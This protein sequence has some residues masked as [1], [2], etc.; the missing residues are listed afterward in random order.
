MKFKDNQ[1]RPIYHQDRI[2]I[3]IKSNVNLIN[4]D[5]KKEQ[6]QKQFGV[7]SIDNI[8]EK[9]PVQKIE[10]AFRQR[11]ELP[12]KVKERIHSSSVTVPDLSQIHLIQFSEKIDA[13]K[14]IKE[15]NKNPEIEYAE[16]V[17]CDY[18]QDVPNDSLYSE[19]QHLPQIKAEQAWE[20]IKGENSDSTILIGICDTGTDWNH[21][22]LIDNLWQNL[23]EDA[24]KDG[25]VIEW[26]DSLK[27]F[28]LD[29]GD[30]NDIDDD[31]N[32]FVD[33]LIGWDFLKDYNTDTQGNNPEDFNNH[34]THVAGI[35]AGVTNNSIGIASVSWNV[36][37]V[38]TSHSAPGF[39]YILRGFDGI[40]YLA[41]LGCDVINCSWGGGGYSKANA[42]AIKYANSLGALVVCAAG[43]DNSPDQFYPSAYQYVIS[44]ASVASTDLKASYSNYGNFV[45]IS[46]P[47][48][49][50]YVDGGILSCIRNKE[51]A[52]YQGTSMASP[53]AAGC[54][55]LIKS[56]YPNWTNEQ[57]KK[58]VIGTADFIDTLNPNYKNMLGSGRV[59]VYRALTETNVQIPQ[60]LKLDLVHVETDD[61]TE[62]S[63]KNK[64]LEPGENVR[65]G[66]LMRNYSILTG[67]NL[68][69]LTLRCYDDDIEVI[70]SVYNVEFTPDGYTETPLEFEVKISENVKSKFVKLELTA[71]S[72]DAEILLGNTMEFYLPVNAGG[73]LIWE[74]LNNAN[75]YSGAFISDFLTKHGVENIYSN[76]FPYSLVGYDAVLLSFGSIGIPYS[77]TSLND[78]MAS[79]I[80]DYLK[81]GGKLYIEG[82]DILGFDQ[83]MNKEFLSLLGIDSS[84]DG[85]DKS[86]SIDTLL[87]QSGTICEG[88]QF[89]RANMGNFQSI[90]LI[91][92]NES[93]KVALIEPMI[94]NIAIQ[95]EG[96]YGQKTFSCVYPI[97]HFVDEKHPNSRYELV[98]RILEFLGIKMNYT[99]PRFAYYPRTGHA[100]LSVSYRDES[101][102][103]RN[104]LSREWDFEGTGETIIT[105]GDNTTNEFK[106]KGDYLSTMTVNTDSNSYTISNPIY[107]FDGESAAFFENNTLGQI[108]DTT[109]NIRDDFTVEAWIMP[110]NISS[111]GWEVIMDKTNVSFDINNGRS[112]RLY[113][114]HQDKS[115]TDFTT[116][117]ESV[118]FT[119]WQ[120]VAVTFDGD[121]T[122]KLYINGKEQ[123][124]KFSKGPG[125]GIIRDNKNSSFTV[126]R[127]YEWW[128]GFEGRID[129]FRF[130]S[131]VRSEAEL[132]SGMFRKLTG[133]EDSLMLYWRFNEGNGDT[134]KD[135]SPH[136]RTCKLNSDW[137]LGIHEG[138]IVS[139]PKSN[140]VCEGQ[141]YVISAQVVSG[142]DSLVYQWAKDGKLLQTTALP[143]YFIDSM[144]KS[145]IGKY[146]L[147]LTNAD[148]YDREFSDTANI[149]MEGNPSLTQQPEPNV[150][151]NIGDTLKLKV[152]AESKSF[153]S[154]EWFKNYEPLY[155]YDAEYI[156]ENVSNDDA[157]EYYCIV[158]NHCG[159][160]ESENSVVTIISGVQENEN[161]NFSFDVSPNPINE[162]TKLKIITD[163]SGYSNVIITDIL[164]Q[165]IFSKK[166]FINEQGQNT[167]N[168]FNDVDFHSSGIYF[169]TV[170]LS[171]KRKTKTLIYRK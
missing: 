62:N 163:F 139:Q 32:G 118:T 157:G 75:G 67:S 142:A 128:N 138:H 76:I 12:K 151:L 148:T 1:G 130:W 41:E 3:K 135:F 36:K 150:I 88:L 103:S 168:L 104:I 39:N 155:F 73:I 19:C 143:E 94:G 26:D 86:H 68:T 50:T 161:V 6:P 131:K 22:D 21:P 170:E 33:D 49:L 31:G 154:Y 116:A 95:N 117:P 144:S 141:S 59:N 108:S 169:V 96:E 11:Q 110:S 107:V 27:L 8:L 164:G 81:N 35:S 132:R 112:L 115:V 105:A 99:I 102:T 48:G 149:G 47:G 119:K 167:I 9:Y 38:P 25:K 56:K 34:G 77:S 5:H 87:G 23:A 2:Y 126:G 43:N 145:D 147:I 63:N 83:M 100:P 82:M 136:K 4:Y 111:D 42:E 28:I 134:A 92:P 20:I 159:S 114:Y 51:Y 18:L 160:I 74:G 58:Q 44:V 66:F 72:E 158:N 54:F 122:F 140:T 90:D 78:W 80:E 120:H 60:T 16:L 171:N 123:E 101:Y 106:V 129:E 156:K 30:L 65:I 7:V 162:N 121:S 15:L 52:R 133:S 91:F 24:D 153:T 127:H 14:L 137:R 71:Q 57:L 17:P 37:F 84:S 85:S 29:P 97:R 61:S 109:L 46:T 79:D 124:L 40:V 152:I 13:I 69:K 98:R 89:L 125:K 45:D 93:G 10:K 70:D 53:V 64:A 113:V 166:I 55:A 165:R 146:M